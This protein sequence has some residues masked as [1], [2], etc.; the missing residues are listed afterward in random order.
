MS[1]VQVVGGFL[2]GQKSLT[3]QQ[4]TSKPQVNVTRHNMFLEPKI[5]T[6]DGPKTFLWDEIGSLIRSSNW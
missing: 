3:P 5:E 4:I 6:L 2:W 1:Y